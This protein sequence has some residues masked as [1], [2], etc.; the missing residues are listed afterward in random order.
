M[1][2]AEAHARGWA[3]FPIGGDSYKRP[4]VKWRVYQATP[5]KIARWTAPRVTGYGIDTGRSRLVVLDEDKP[6]A[7]AALC[8]LHGE[9]LPPTHT[10]RTAKGQHLYFLVP[11]SLIVRNSA[12]TVLGPGVDVRAYGGYVVGSGSLHAS[13]TVYVTLDDADPAPLPEWLVEL[14][15]EAPGRRE[16]EPPP[17]P[18]Y[19]DETSEWGRAVLNDAVTKIGTAKQGTR[20][21]TLRAEALKVSSLVKGGHIERNMA[22]GALRD[23]A[24]DAGLGSSETEATLV[25][26]ARDARPLAQLEVMFPDLSADEAAVAD[27]ADATTAGASGSGNSVGASITNAGVSIGGSAALYVDLHALVAQDLTVPQPDAGPP[28]PDGHQWLYYGRLNGLFGDSESAKTLAALGILAHELVAGGHGAFI[29]TD[30]NGPQHIVR[31]LLRFGVPLDALDRFRYVEPQVASTVAAIVTDL[32]DNMPRGVV[33]FDSFGENIGLLGG[34]GASANVDE[35][36]IKTHRLT[37]QPVARSGHCALVIDHIAKNAGSREY[38]A[39]GSS[40]KKRIVDGAYLEAKIVDEFDPVT[41]GQSVLL[42]KKDRTGGIRALGIK[43]NEQVARFRIGPL[44]GSDADGNGGTQ[45]V[46][47]HL[48]DLIV[49]PNASNPRAATEVALDAAGVLPGD[50]IRA[51]VRKVEALYNSTERKTL[52]ITR[53]R[54]RDVFRDRRLRSAEMF[55]ETADSTDLDAEGDVECATN[56]PTSK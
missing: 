46:E 23:A 7:L 36:V 56:P 10:V 49:I 20:N 6:G 27:E 4:L 35:S 54:V 47:F 1:S 19:A 41:G 21:E 29:D 17:I 15:G 52:G 16:A 33:V 51:G 25:G 38:G 2:A 42:L 24:D 31:T 50:S 37:S 39:T 8:E 32:C 12:S 34:P 18:T 43:T 26:A 9:T 11:E 5:E 40:A 3:V 48:P 22:V 13:G 30:Y 55:P 44:T 53:D 45:T 28:R 14:L